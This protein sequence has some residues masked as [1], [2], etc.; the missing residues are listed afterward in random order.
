M[1]T[2]YDIRRKRLRQLIQTQFDNNQ[3]EISRHLGRSD[4][5]INRLLADP[6]KSKHAKNLGEELAREIESLCGLPNGWLDQ[7]NQ[8]AT[9]ADSK[10]QLPGFTMVP[11]RLVD[12][13][14]GNGSLAYAEEDAPPLAFRSEWL[15]KEGLTPRNLVVAYVRGD[16]MTPRLHDGDTILIDTSRTSPVDGAVFAVRYGDELRV[17]RVF[18][19]IDSITLHSDN[20]DYPSED[21]PYSKLADLHLIGRVVWVAGSV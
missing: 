15:S 7:R 4:S 16:S 10:A 1:D 13:S 11:R 2:I 17:K 5:Y 9:P 3:S 18:R 12:L 8:V 6:N 20:P 14:A 19:K 21:I